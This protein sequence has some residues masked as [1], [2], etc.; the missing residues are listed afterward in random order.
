LTTKQRVDGTLSRLLLHGKALFDTYR[1]AGGRSTDLIRTRRNTALSHQKG[2]LI[3]VLA[4][5]LVCSAR[6][7]LPRT[8][9]ARGCGPPS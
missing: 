8:D 9:G 2:T 1:A 3:G 5:Y 7:P 6:R 4:G